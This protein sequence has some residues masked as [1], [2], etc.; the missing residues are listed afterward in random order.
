MGLTF[1]QSN[2]IMP[3][4]ASGAENDNSVDLGKNNSRFK[5]LYLSGGAYIGGTGSANKLD[6]YEEGTWTPTISTGTAY[7]SQVGTY[8]KI[9]N[10]VHVKCN[11]QI[12]S[13]SA[14]TNLLSGLPF[15]SESASGQ[16][17]GGV[18]VMYYANINEAVTWLSGYVISNSSTIYFSGNAGSNITIGKNGF[19]VFK[20]STRILF[21]CTYQTA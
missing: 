2:Y 16:S 9:G 17:S 14:I 4:N 5:D 18:N 12:T 7:A 8:T 19:N 15:T 10:V 21:T 20:A 13:L 6:D 11:I 3:S 1:N